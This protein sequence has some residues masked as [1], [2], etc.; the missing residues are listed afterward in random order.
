[1]G[2]IKL[3]FEGV[4]REVRRLNKQA[5]KKQEQFCES[6]HELS[7]CFK[8]ILSSEMNGNHHCCLT[9]QTCPELYAKELQGIGFSVEEMRNGANT[10]CGYIISWDEIK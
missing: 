10:L 4:I 9:V 2:L 3:E 8:W 7:E 1:M 6:T 5:L